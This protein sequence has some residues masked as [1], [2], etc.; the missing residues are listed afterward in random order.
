METKTKIL[1]AILI[2]AA[3]LRFYKLSSNPPGLY[4]DEISFGY[5]AYS[6]LKTG[7]D[8]YGVFLPTLLKSF[9]DYKAPL[10]AYLLVP[11]IGVFGLNEFAVRF[12][13]A[14]LGTL[15]IILVYLLVSQI[16]QD[17]NLGLIASFLHTI[18][19]WHLQFSRAGFEA[20]VMV[21]FELLGLLLFL[22]SKYRLKF[23]LMSSVSFGLAFQAY[24]GARVWIPLYFLVIGMLYWRELLGH[25]KKLVLPTLI[26]LV[27][28]S[29]AILNFSKATTRAYVTIFKEPNASQ[30]FIENYLSHFSPVFLFFSGDPIGR[31]SVPGMGEL[32]IFLI[33]FI[34]TGLVILVKKKEREYKLL[35]AWFLFAPIPASIANPSPHALRD[36]T[37]LPLWSTISALGIM[38]Y[39]RSKINFKIKL[40]GFLIVGIVAAYNIATY[41]HLYYVHYPKEKAVDWSV[42]VKEMISYVESHKENYSRIYITNNYAIPYIY[43]LFYTKY[44][45]KQYIAENGNSNHFGK[46]YFYNHL[47]EISGENILVV[48]DSGGHPKN[49]FKDIIINNNNLIYR[50]GYQ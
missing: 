32:Y 24:H 37:S 15:S 22:K 28:I 4:L 2:L 10:Y 12:P 35:L 26:F 20:N 21:F 19:P 50:I 36:I 44:D 8:E 6:I 14:L 5:N 49:E 41:F 7:R 1:L 42:G 43:F 45:P 46:Y 34:F 11:S 27:I 29:P 3:F 38:A 31:H 16:F 9:G 33:P 17:K 47:E 30:V 25:W 39:A 40:T 18:S 48:S 23:L 13:S